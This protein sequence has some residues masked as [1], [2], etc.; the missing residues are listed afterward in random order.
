M[1][2][3]G[4]GE[5]KARKSGRKYYKGSLPYAPGTKVVLIKLSDLELILES[6]EQALLVTKKPMP[7]KLYNIENTRD[8][9]FFDDVMLYVAKDKTQYKLFLDRHI[10]STNPKDMIWVRFASVDES[11]VEEQDT[12]KDGKE[13]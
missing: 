1:D 4:K 10:Y 8:I 6:S 11:L 9:P 5:I 7:K 12:F 2:Y 3:P 13:H